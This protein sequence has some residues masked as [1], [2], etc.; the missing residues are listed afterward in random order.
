MLW[1]DKVGPPST[2]AGD[3]GQGDREEPGTLL[4]LAI[5][6]PAPTVL[7]I[8]RARRST[9]RFPLVE[10][11]TLS[12]RTKRPFCCPGGVTFVNR[13]AVR[14]ESSFLGTA[15]WEMRRSSQVS[16]LKYLLEGG[17]VAIST[18]GMAES[19]SDG[20]RRWLQ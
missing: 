3:T 4:L 10:A 7:L 2:H 1:E 6:S 8:H 15:P 9:G 16:R 5:L 14:S 13:Q 11:T 20:E 17:Q 18:V 12:T 19:D